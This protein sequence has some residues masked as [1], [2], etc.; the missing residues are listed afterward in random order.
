MFPNSLFYTVVFAPSKQEN[1]L[2]I[3]GFTKG[4]LIQ[5]KPRLKGRILYF[6]KRETM[7]RPRRIFWEEQGKWK[8]YPPENTIQE[9]MAKAKYIFLTSDMSNKEKNGLTQFCID[10]NIPIKLR[11]ENV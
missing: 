3:L 6:Y 10:F 5:R 7:W 9:I 4:T 1:T 11:E 2:Q 8:A